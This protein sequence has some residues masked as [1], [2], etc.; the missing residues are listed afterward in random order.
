[1]RYLNGINQ[2]FNQIRFINDKP[3][4]IIYEEKSTIC[5]KISGSINGDSSFVLDLIEKIQAHLYMLF[6]CR[7]VDPFLE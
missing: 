4:D 5:P 6:N 2:R 3:N 7:E 1:M